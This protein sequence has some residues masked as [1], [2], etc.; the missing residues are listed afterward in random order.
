LQW[1]QLVLGFSF[2]ELW[3]TINFPECLT[4]MAIKMQDTER[5]EEIQEAFQVFDKDGNGY[6]SAL[7]GF[8][9]VVLNTKVFLPVLASRL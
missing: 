7:Q 3:L 8:T 6:I 5:E 9:R 4:M 1:L 2:F